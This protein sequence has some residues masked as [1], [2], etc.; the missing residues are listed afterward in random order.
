VRVPWIVRWPGRVEPGVT[1]EPVHHVDLFPTIG[2]VAGV[3]LGD[4]LELDGADL[5]AL[6]LERAPLARR[7]L[8]W[9]F[10]C[11]LEGRSGRFDRIRTVPG[12]SVVS[13]GWKLV[14]FFRPR[15]DEVPRVELYH[16]SSDPREERDLADAEPERVRALLAELRA[17]RAA[18]GARVPREPEPRYELR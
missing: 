13:D 3:D 5:S 15:G 9:H 7:S 10:P 8:H 12:G 11:Y 14:E 6:L 16:L 18:V 17:W 2:A 1:D 4:G